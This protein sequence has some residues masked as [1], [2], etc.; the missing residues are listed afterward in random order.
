MPDPQQ[1]N[2]T[3]HFHSPLTFC[4]QYIHYTTVFPSLSSGTMHFTL[5][6][7]ERQK[8]RSLSSLSTAIKAS[9]GTCTLP[10][11]RIFFA[12][13]RIFDSLTGELY[14]NSRRWAAGAAAHR[15]AKRSVAIQLEH[16][17]KGIGRHLHFAQVPHLLFCLWKSS[18]LSQVSLDFNSRRWAAV[19]PRTGRQK[20][21]SL[22][23]L[24]TP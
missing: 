2:F 10:R 4:K 24:S 1:Q 11:F 22:S 13:G 19:P 14:F 9:V 16:G 18:I 20:D 17:H 5:C 12:C 7:R 23:S 21:Q 8:D 15:K 6:A 3:L